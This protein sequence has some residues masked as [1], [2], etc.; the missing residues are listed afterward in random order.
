MWRGA[1]PT[2]ATL[3]TSVRRNTSHVP[4]T[5]DHTRAASVPS[6]QEQYWPDKVCYGCGPS[7]PHG[8]HVRSHVVFDGFTSGASVTG[9]AQNA[10]QNNHGDIVLKSVAYFT[11]AEHH[12]ALPGVLNG[13]IIASV[14]DC[15]CNIAAAYCLMRVAGRAELPHMTVTADLRVQFKAP[16]P[17]GRLRFCAIVRQQDIVTAKRK[18]VVTGYVIE[19]KDHVP[20]TLPSAQEDVLLP[21]VAVNT[22]LFGGTFVAMS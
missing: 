11:P 18:V 17:M 13:G 12:Q 4:P 21:S 20:L 16:T 9:T 1:S 8:L 22:A 14:F 5:M 7:N 6:L 2:A 15:H 19:D 10:A 3:C